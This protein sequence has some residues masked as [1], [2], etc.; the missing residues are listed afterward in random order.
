MLFCSLTI[1]IEQLNNVPGS[2]FI[3]RLRTQTDDQRRIFKSQ[4]LQFSLLGLIL[5][6][7]LVI[8]H[9]FLGKISSLGGV[10]FNLK[11]K[12]RNDEAEIKTM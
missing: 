12:R 5:F 8:L 10:P 9:V 11:R 1:I 6:I 3:F 2:G 4:I 7:Y